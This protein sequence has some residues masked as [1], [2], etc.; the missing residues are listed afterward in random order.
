ML[1]TVSSTN[2]MYTILGSSGMSGMTE[3]I[4]NDWDDWKARTAVKLD[5]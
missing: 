3:K 1:Q 4:E 5:D 2:N